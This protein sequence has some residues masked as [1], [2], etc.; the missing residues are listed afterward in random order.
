MVEKIARVGLVPLMGIPTIAKIRVQENKGVVIWP[1][2]VVY[3]GM[4]FIL[5]SVNEND[6]A[7]YNQEPYKEDP[8]VPLEEVCAEQ[9][10]I[11]RE[12]EG[13]V[14]KQTNQIHALLAR[15]SDAKKNK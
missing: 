1:E 14:A 11:I 7:T 12:L 8:E 15:L 13:L 4:T 3:S 6:S 9:Q 2:R 10:E 5:K